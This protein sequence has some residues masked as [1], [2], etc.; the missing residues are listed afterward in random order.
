MFFLFSDDFDQ[1]MFAAHA[2]EFIIEN[3]FPGAEIEL[4]VGDGDDGFSAHDRAFEM[5]V[6]VVLKAV[7]PVLVIGF[8]RSEGFEPFFIVGMEAGLVIVDEDAGGDVHGVDEDEAF[9]DA[10]FGQGLFHVRGD[11]DD[12][13]AFG[14]VEE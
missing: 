9:F 14:N 1:G 10:A 3:L 13:S 11:V 5:G 12:L 6:G 7:V 4:A 8:F 2:V